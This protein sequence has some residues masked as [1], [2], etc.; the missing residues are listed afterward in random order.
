MDAYSRQHLDSRAQA[1]PP[2][3]PKQEAELACEDLLV[4]IRD[5][6]DVSLRARASDRE[7]QVAV[8]TSLIGRYAA[9]ARAAEA[10]AEQLLK[11]LK[12]AL[13]AFFYDRTQQSDALLRHALLSY[14]DLAE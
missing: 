10:P 11:P 4:Q 7:A 2:M 1:S 3:T 8:L 9:C 12:G 5:A 6:A 13:G 14:F